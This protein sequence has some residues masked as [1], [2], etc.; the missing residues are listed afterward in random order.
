MNHESK[1]L[2]CGTVLA[3]DE[4]VTSTGVNT[5]GSVGIY[6]TGNP[7][8]LKTLTQ[9]YV[10]RDILYNSAVQGHSTYNDCSGSSM[11]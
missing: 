10:D 1:Q 5:A 8:H 4:E 6:G 11:F 2:V 7:V 3:S 9:I